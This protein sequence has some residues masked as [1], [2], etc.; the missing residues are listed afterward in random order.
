MAKKLDEFKEIFQGVSD[1]QILYSN[2]SIDYIANNYLKESN[3]Y[4]EESKKNRRTKK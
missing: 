2:Y 1:L 3:K 4:L